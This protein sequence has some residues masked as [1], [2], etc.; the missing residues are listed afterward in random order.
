MSDRKPAVPASIDSEHAVLGALMLDPHAVDRVG[1]LQPGHFFDPLN[2]EVYSAIVGLL[3]AGSAADPVTVFEHLRLRAATAASRP[4]LLAHLMSLTNEVPSSANVHRYAAFVRDRATERALLQLGHDLAELA[5]GAESVPEKLATAQARIT[6]LSEHVVRR[7]P[8]AWAT[9]YNQW[10]NTAEARSNG[11]TRVMG[12]GLADLDRDLA[13]GLRP[14]QLA[15]LGARPGM[16]KTAL[17]QTIAAHVSRDRSVLFCSMEMPAAD[18]HDRWTAMIGRVP[19]DRVLKADEHDS[20]LWEA[21]THTAQAALERHLAVDDQAALRLV[22]VR[23]K[24]MGVKRRSGLDLLV[25]DYLQLMQGDARKESRNYQ[26][27][28][29]SRGLKALAKELDIAVLALVQL[30]RGVEDRRDGIPQ[31][32]DIRDC[33][34][35]EADADVIAFIDRPIKRNPDL[36]LD[37]QHFAR[38]VLAKNRQGKTGLVGLHFDGAFQTFAN[39]DGPWPQEASAPTGFSRRRGIAA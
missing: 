27:E 15:L 26:L 22:D 21:A 29:I 10:V 39:W 33:G 25:I 17:A 13:G 20:Q 14:G 4:D 32:S 9:S 1:D 28:E 16:G 31:M 2:A 3:G 19:L 34:A 6:A 7:E 12:T 30:N 38:L 36:G 18:L 5:R 11:K 24:A 35:I 8:V 37:W 23:L